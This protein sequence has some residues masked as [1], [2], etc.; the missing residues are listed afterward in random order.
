MNL[1]KKFY[2]FVWQYKLSFILGSVFMILSAV[3]EN[4]GSY[5]SKYIIDNISSPT[6]DMIGFINIIAGFVV[7]MPLT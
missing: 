3:L 4:L 7:I 5:Y 6:P 2:K 1:F